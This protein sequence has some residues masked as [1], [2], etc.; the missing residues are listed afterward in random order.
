M[1]FRY[2]EMLEKNEGAL[3]RRTKAVFYRL[4]AGSSGIDYQHFKEYVYQEDPTL[5]V[6]TLTVQRAMRKRLF[7]EPYWENFTKRRKDLYKADIV[8]ERR[9]K[10]VLKHEADLQSNNAIPVFKD[11]FPKIENKLTEGKAAKVCV[12]VIL[13]LKGDVSLMGARCDSVDAG[14]ERQ[15]GQGQ[16]LGGCPAE[17]REDAPLLRGPG[18][19]G[20]QVLH[21]EAL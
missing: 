4:G 13:V 6:Y 11:D 15:S 14:E 10:D 12:Q 17:E 5:M 18:G 19:E 20:H 9:I 1:H 8:L 21:A 2:P 3:I 16:V 7:G